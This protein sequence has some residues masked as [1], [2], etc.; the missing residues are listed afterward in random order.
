M[1]TRRARPT[2]L[3]SMEVQSSC[4]TLG[5]TWLRCL[6]WRFLISTPMAGAWWLT[7]RLRGSQ[8]PRTHCSSPTRATSGTTGWWSPT[9]GGRTRPVA[10]PS[11]CPSQPATAADWT[12][13]GAACTTPTGTNCLSPGLLAFGRTTTTWTSRCPGRSRKVSLGPRGW[14]STLR[15]TSRCTTMSRT[16]SSRTSAASI[17]TPTS[18]PGPRATERTTGLRCPCLRTVSRSATTSSRRWADPN[19]RPIRPSTAGATRSGTWRAAGAIS[20]RI[21]PTRPKARAAFG[22]RGAAATG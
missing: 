9:A 13:N 7:T 15:R 12:E 10:R 2:A 4:V 21:R 3:S 19:G 20:W 8:T 1:D 14:S 17:P 18:I 11:T 16:P 5:E 22:R 6:P